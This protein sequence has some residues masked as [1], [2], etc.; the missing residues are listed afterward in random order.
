MT[1]L[2]QLILKENSMFRVVAMSEAT[3]KSCSSKC[4]SVIKN[5]PNTAKEV[6]T[7][8]AKCKIGALTSAIVSLQSMRRMGVDNR[9]LDSKIRYLQLRRIKE[10]GKKKNHANDLNGRRTTISVSQSLRPSKETPLRQQ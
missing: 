9:I 3:M 4:R 6:S 5:G 8:I 2:A 1:T 7:C 10:M